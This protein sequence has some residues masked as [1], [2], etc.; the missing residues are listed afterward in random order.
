MIERFTLGLPAFW[1]YRWFRITLSETGMISMGLVQERRN[2]S[3]L[4]MDLLLP[5]ANPSI[6]KM[7]DGVWHYFTALQQWF[8]YRQPYMYVY[9]VQTLTTRHEWYPHT[10]TFCY[11]N[12]NPQKRKK[13]QDDFVFIDYV[14][15]DMNYETLDI[16]LQMKCSVM[17]FFKRWLW[18]WMAFF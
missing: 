10:L 17:Y 14:L 11:N 13:N 18:F 8:K 3:V 6:L 4:A 5:C 12:I 7:V 15:I 16:M 1:I 9:V 2:S